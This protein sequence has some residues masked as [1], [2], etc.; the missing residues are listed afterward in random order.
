MQFT[1][2]QCVCVC[3]CGG[4]K[5]AEIS[6]KI[7]RWND[8][9][10]NTSLP[11]LCLVSRLSFVTRRAKQLQSCFD[12]YPSIVKDTKLVVSFYSILFFFFSIHFSHFLRSL[13]TFFLN[14]YR[15]K[16]EDGNKRLNP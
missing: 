1:A 10:I 14:Q 12:R 15:R 9:A 2:I 11:A 5:N 6:G 3:V 8:G 7:I 16:T 13:L 4:P